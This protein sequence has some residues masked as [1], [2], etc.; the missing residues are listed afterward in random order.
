MQQLS[1]LSK[2][3]ERLRKRVM[4]LEVKLMDVGKEE[5]KKLK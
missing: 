5:E 3:L 1:V 2:D 4:E